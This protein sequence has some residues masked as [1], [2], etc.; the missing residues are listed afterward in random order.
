[1]TARRL[2]RLRRSRRREGRRQTTRCGAAGV[3]YLGA[4]ASSPMQA[5]ARKVPNSTAEVL[6]Q[7]D[8]GLA[9]AMRPEARPW[10]GE[11]ERLRQSIELT[12]DGGY[13]RVVGAVDRDVDVVKGEDGVCFARK[14]KEQSASVGLWEQ[15][16]C[17]SSHEKK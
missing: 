14:V 13:V 8:A 10:T 3:S 5:S 16:L 15:V 12:G 2:E 6:G 7:W 11:E 9:R 1:M 4:R 17:A